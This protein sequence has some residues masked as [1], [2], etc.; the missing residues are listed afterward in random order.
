MD[1]AREMD[2]LMAVFLSL[3]LSS[4][5]AFRSW[6]TRA[7]SLIAISST[8]FRRLALPLDNNRGN[9]SRWVQQ[10]VAIKLTPQQQL[11]SARL[12]WTQQGSP[13]I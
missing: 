12:K 7:R 2:E 11:K 13:T 5:S 3:L 10:I 1:P 9:K 6:S 4:M 8:T